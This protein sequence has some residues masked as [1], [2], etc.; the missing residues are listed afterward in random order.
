MA[1]SQEEEGKSSFSAEDA[2][3]LVEFGAAIDSKF[4]KID[5]AYAATQLALKAVQD[6][7]AL[8]QTCKKFVMAFT[9]S[10][11]KVSSMFGAVWMYLIVLLL[12]FIFHQIFVW[13]DQ[14]PDVAFERAGLLFEGTEI[15]WDLTSVLWNSGVDVFNA[16]VIP[17]WN[18]ATYY[19]VEPTVVLSLEVFSLVFMQQ[20]WSGLFSE[21]D[22][23]YNGLDCLANSE[24]AAWCGR[25]G[26]YK[27]ALESAAYAA[28]YVNDSDTYQGRRRLD[29]Q[30]YTFGLATA[31]HLQE[32]SG[33]GFSAPTFDS[34]ALTEALESLSVFFVTMLPALL[35]VAFGVIG[36]V[37]RTSF[38]VIMDAV[39]QVLKSVFFVLKMIIK[40]GMITTLVG[41]GVDFVLIFFTEIAIPLLFAAIDTL[42]CLLDYFS[43]S[44]WNGQLECDFTFEQT[45]KQTH[46]Y[47]P[48]GATKTRCCSRSQCAL[49]SRCVENTCFKGPDAAS[50]VTAFFSMPIILHRYMAIMDATLNSRTGQRLVNGVTTG[51]FTTKGRTR[52]P[53]T[54][55]AINN[56][57]PE[58]AAAGN[59]VTGEFSLADNWQ[60]F[61]GTT[62]ADECSKCFTCKVSFRNIQ[63]SLAPQARIRSALTLTRCPSCASSGG[64]RPASARSSRGKTTTS[65]RAT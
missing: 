39:F 27:A 17:L 42:M 6:A 43:P 49:V 9:N 62:A 23:P 30:N 13:V 60:D 33:G 65:S 14:D 15:A 19:L 22:F 55:E 24:S 41:I 48:T 31:R 1:S 51:S 28:A 7:L 45:H 12:L 56:E 21:A 61:I 26:V 38:S 40:S 20:H 5:R 64:S 52:N 16:G 58:T 2:Q 44:G 29:E 3:R 37:I 18:S 35:D 59:P 47:L 63:T 50:D 36:D 57:E 8:G 32:L 53:D 54:G 25:Y 11:S 46:T 10:V 4:A 34:S